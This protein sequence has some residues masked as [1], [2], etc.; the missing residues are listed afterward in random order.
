LVGLL[1]CA[2]A[3]NAKIPTVAQNNDD[4]STGLV[5]F[6]LKVNKDKQMLVLIKIQ[7]GLKTKHFDLI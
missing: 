1:V 7:L 2:Q 6:H 4:F 5:I 3:D